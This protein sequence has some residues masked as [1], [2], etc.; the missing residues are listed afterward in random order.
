MFNNHSSCFF[1]LIFFHSIS[2]II[3]NFAFFTCKSPEYQMT[4]H[5]SALST[6]PGF[7]SYIFRLILRFQNCLISLIWITCKYAS[8]TLSIY[9]HT[10]I[11]IFIY[12][13]SL[14]LNAAYL[15]QIKFENSIYSWLVLFFCYSLP[16]FFS[17]AR[18]IFISNL[19]VS[20]YIY[21][22]ICVCDLASSLRGIYVLHSYN[23]HEFDWFFWFVIPVECCC[24]YLLQ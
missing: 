22:Y 14:L 15:N 1:F 10:Y 6:F 4:N 19:Y 24:C 2:L 12:K 13:L 23:F 17:V 16:F 21:T 5:I 18:F 11:Y 9:T 8:Y 7:R 20:I 3:I